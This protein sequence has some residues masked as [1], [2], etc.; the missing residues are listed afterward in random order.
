MTPRI[1]ELPIPGVIVV[2]LPPAADNPRVFDEEFTG[3][4]VVPV[5]KQALLFDIRYSGSD[6]SE[7]DFINLPPGN[8][9]LIGRLSEATEEQATGLVYKHEWSDGYYLYKD[10]EDKLPK[11]FYHN[12]IT[13]LESLHSAIKAAGLFTENPYG[14]ELHDAYKPKFEHQIKGSRHEKWHEAQQR[15]ICPE[16][17]VVLSKIRR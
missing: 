13:A 3:K 6:G 8:W 12:R 9:Q 2:E 11:D 1:F 10:Y 16:R 7:T 5:D 15:T 14:K 17:T 4:H